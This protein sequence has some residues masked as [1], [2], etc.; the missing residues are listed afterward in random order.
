MFGHLK[1]QRNA[2]EMQDLNAQVA[3]GS[4]IYSEM[5]ESE[6]H[7]EMQ[8]SLLLL[9][10]GENHVV[11]SSDSESASKAEKWM[12]QIIQCINPVASE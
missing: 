6:N 4:R 10:L 12:I 3:V 9:T 11:E 5:Q 2:N 8:D 7:K 1:G